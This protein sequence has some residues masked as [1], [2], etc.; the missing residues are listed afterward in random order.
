MLDACRMYEPSSG[1]AH[2]RVLCYSEVQHQS[3]ETVSPFV[4]AYVHASAR[5]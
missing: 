3:A 2:H 1:L 4:R 5:A